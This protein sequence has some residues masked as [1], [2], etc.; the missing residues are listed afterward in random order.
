MCRS[1]QLPLPL[2]FLYHSSGSTPPQMYMLQLRKARTSL[3][4]ARGEVEDGQKRLAHRETRA[5]ELES[6]VGLHP[7]LVRSGQGGCAKG[8]VPVIGLSK[9]SALVGG[10]A[11]MLTHLTHHCELAFIQLPGRPRRCMPVP[12]SRAASWP[13]QLRLLGS[14]S[15]WPNSSSRRQR[16][17]CGRRCSVMSGEAPAGMLRWNGWA[18]P[19]HAADAE[20][21]WAVSTACMV[22]VDKQACRQAS[23]QT[24]PPC[25]PLNPFWFCLELPLSSA[26]MLLSCPS[27]RAWWPRPS[28]SRLPLLPPLTRRSVHS[29]WR[30]PAALC[31]QGW[32]ALW[33]P[34]RPSCRT[35]GLGPKAVKWHVLAD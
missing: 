8:H 21:S 12:P 9:A 23:V 14:A 16:P 35:G 27:G 18:P 29:S 11:C 25:N 20:A 19:S 28:G 33:M 1:R 3:E 26:G 7:R 34:G 30:R 13:T 24:Q 2:H 31:W 10:S 6:Q 5:A 15:Q 32:S 4:L 22:A 17:N